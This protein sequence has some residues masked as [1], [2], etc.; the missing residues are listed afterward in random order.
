MNA[1][2][3]D[4][5][6]NLEATLLSALCL[7]CGQ[8]CGDDF[9]P[10][11]LV[12]GYRVLGVQAEPPETDPDGAVALTVFDTPPQGE[13]VRYRWSVCL[14][15]FGPATDYACVDPALER[16]LDGDA[17]TA[18]LDLGPDGLDLRAAYERFG[19]VP[20]PNGVPLTLADGVDVWVILRSGPADGSGRQIR[21]AKRVHVR[22]GGTPN[23][24]PAMLE[25]THAGALEAGGVVTLRALLDEDSLEPE[26]DLLLTWYTSAGEVAPSISFGD[27]R[28]TELTLPDAPGPIDVFVA[29][30]D[31]RGGLDVARATLE[32]R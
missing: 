29:A 24:N 12:A 27:D 19:P 26:D 4:L 18:T 20:D 31:S 21:T 3:F 17:A 5:T 11:S 10:K 8:G 13:A 25:L 9:D 22:D 7:L 28:E 23:Q 15:S 16:S 1:R 14:W 6:L 32:V 2:N 30:R